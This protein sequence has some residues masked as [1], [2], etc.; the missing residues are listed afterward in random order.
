M[1]PRKKTLSISPD[2]ISLSHAVT[3]GRNY[4]PQT[5]DDEILESEEL[6]L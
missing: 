1:L 2:I 6:I 3:I 5:S 4:I